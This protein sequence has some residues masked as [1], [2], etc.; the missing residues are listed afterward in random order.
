M[1]GISDKELIA[2]GA[3]PPPYDKKDAVVGTGKGLAAD[4]KTNADLNAAK[5]ANPSEPGV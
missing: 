5:M 4:R 2:R 3:A 1:M